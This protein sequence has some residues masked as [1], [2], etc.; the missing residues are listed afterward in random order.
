M[1][2]PPDVVDVLLWRLAADVM[3]EHQP[4]PDGHCAN[5]RCADEQG[6]CAAAIQARHALRAARRRTAAA[7]ATPGPQPPNHAAARRTSERPQSGA[8]VGRAPVRTPNT[9]RFTG[10]FTNTANAITRWRPEQRLPQRTPGLA[11]R[12]A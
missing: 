11:I 6:P 5:L 2:I 7:A 3:I 8:A 4:G 12:T 1:P 9:G 10:W